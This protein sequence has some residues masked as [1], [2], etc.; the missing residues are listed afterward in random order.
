MTEETKQALKA[1]A[2]SI[3]DCAEL[4]GYRL[5]YTSLD[6]STPSEGDKDSDSVYLYIRKDDAGEYVTTIGETVSK[7]ETI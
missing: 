7:S 3:I 4:E 2:S 1:L 5:S 6:W